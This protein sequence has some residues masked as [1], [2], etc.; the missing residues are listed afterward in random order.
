MNIKK[1][2]F[3]LSSAFFILSIVS[4][5][6]SASEELQSFIKDIKTAEKSRDKSNIS[7]IA[8]I[9][10]EKYIKSG[11][12]IESDELNDFFYIF[13]KASFYFPDSVEF[14]EDLEIISNKKKEKNILTEED[15][16]ILLRSL[17]EARM[18]SKAREFSRKYGL[19][20]YWLPERDLSLT[21]INTGNRVLFISEDKK[22]LKL[23]NIDLSKYKAVMV[24]SPTCSVSR[25]AI[26]FLLSQKEV[27]DI[28][29]DKTIFLTRK[30]VPLEIEDFK[31]EY[32]LKDV[33]MVFNSGDFE[34]FY[35]YF[36]PSF[37]FI[38]EGKVISEIK[39]FSSDEGGKPFLKRFL[40]CLE[41]VK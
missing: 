6:L 23:K 15:K 27:S 40:R 2:R 20:D 9:V 10:S 12:N 28:I 34:Q 3:V 16:D 29:R 21:G 26:E 11:K 17:V 5:H 41:G 32:N 24:F 39:G 7:R 36:Y 4:A 31:K 30:Y 19:K 25:E 37:Y 18:I 38:K 33:Y 1:R 22:E 13:K 35:F 8:G 14:V